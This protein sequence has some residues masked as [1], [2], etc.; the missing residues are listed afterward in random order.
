M[1]TLFIALELGNV[2]LTEQEVADMFGVNLTA[3]K[4][5]QMEKCFGVDRAFRRLTDIYIWT[6]KCWYGLYEG[7]LIFVR[8]K[9]V[10]KINLM[11]LLKYSSDLRF[12]VTSSTVGIFDKCTKNILEEACLE[13]ISNF[14]ELRIEKIK[15]YIPKLEHA[16]EILFCTN[17]PY[18]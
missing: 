13:S 12:S 16:Y 17:N 7:K 18:I 9:G 4:I 3:V 1:K 15:P 10:D 11:F 6:C 14:N 8:I 2:I 5:K